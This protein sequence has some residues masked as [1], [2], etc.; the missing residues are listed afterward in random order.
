MVVWRTALW[1]P[2]LI[3]HVFSICTPYMAPQKQYIST[4]QLVQG[5][6]PQFAYQ[7]QLAGPD[8]EAALQSE[9]DI[10]IFF[11]AMSGGRGPNGEVGFSPERGVHLDDL[12]KLKRG[13][14][15]DE[16]VSLF[17]VQC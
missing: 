12:K 15:L 7:L 10:R 4:E 3:S 8:V 11:N 16:K 6:L 5:P 17:I 1:H 13:P 14:L 9:E 2:E